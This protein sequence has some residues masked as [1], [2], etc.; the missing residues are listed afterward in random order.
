[1]F[2]VKIQNACK[3]SK[4]ISKFRPSAVTNY[5]FELEIGVALRQFS[6]SILQNTVTTN[7]DRH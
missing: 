4:N 7:Q 6:F 1:M 2:G 5:I 3:A